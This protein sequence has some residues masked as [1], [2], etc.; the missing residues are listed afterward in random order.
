AAGNAIAANVTIALNIPPNASSK[1]DNYIGL[2]RPVTLTL[3]GSQLISSGAFAPSPLPGN[4]TDE[5]L[6]FDNTITAKNK[7]SSSVYYYWN[8]AWRRVGAGS[9]VVGSDPVFAPGTGIILRKG[10]NS[11][12]TWINTPDF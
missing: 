4:R 3:D 11:Q 5:L 9:A 7:S 8:S 1:Q 2:M 12:A 6:F 10:T